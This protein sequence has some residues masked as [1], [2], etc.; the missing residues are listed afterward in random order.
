MVNK[1]LSNKVSQAV[2]NIELVDCKPGYLHFSDRD[3]LQANL[4]HCA[5]TIARYRLTGFALLVLVTTR[6]HPN[7]G[8][9]PRLS[10]VR[11]QTLAGLSELETLVTICRE[12]ISGAQ[13]CGVSF[14][15]PG[16]LW[17][18]GWH[19]KDLH[20][21]LYLSRI[22]MTLATGY[23][24]C[25]IHTSQLVLLQTLTAFLFASYYHL[26]QFI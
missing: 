14:A 24:L 3:L 26:Q 25:A 1:C 21:R 4:R 2:I 10:R 20:A 11:E 8:F 12:P 6:T 5:S 18:R 13:Q 15:Q 9:F 22:N 7:D 17:E 16:Q 19:L 23:V